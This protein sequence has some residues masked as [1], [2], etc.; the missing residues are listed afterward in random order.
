MHQEIIKW[1]NLTFQD[2]ISKDIVVRSEANQWIISIKGNDCLFFNINPNFYKFNKPTY[3]ESLIV[4]NQSLFFFKFTKE[5]LYFNFDNSHFST[6]YDF[7]GGVF[8][9]M[10]RLEEYN[11]NKLDLHNRYSYF[12]STA[13]E[14]GLILRPII[15][16]YFSLLKLILN[17]IVKDINFNVKKFTVYQTFDIDTP[18]LIINKNLYRICRHLVNSIFHLKFVYSYRILKIW[19]TYKY[20]KNDELDPMNNF[21]K[22]FNSLK[23]FKQE[24]IFFLITNCSNRYRDGD[25]DLKR[26]NIRNLSKSILDNG[27]KLGFHFSFDSYNNIFLLNKEINISKKYNIPFSMISRQ[28][29]LRYDISATPSSLDNMKITNDYTLGF[30]E[31]VGFRCGTSHPF[32][33][34]DFCN[35]KVLELIQNP[36]IAM[37]VTLF[38][39]NYMNLDFN[40][41]REILF[42]LKNEVK[43]H[44]GNLILLWHNDQISTKDRYIFF[45]SIIENISK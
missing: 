9:Y 37:D 10:N 25:S 32:R 45:E 34:F 27:F 22:I 39:K 20:N 43:K 30:P 21:K 7:I 33:M 15:D 26:K 42:K 8:W 4:E 40:Y 44:E 41:A 38:G 36:L 12:N 3:C 24:G 35:M 29:Y 16:E 31:Q 14:F 5:H 6:N 18:F 2:R 11:S 1:V 23:F 17:K 19:I 28:H 13:Y